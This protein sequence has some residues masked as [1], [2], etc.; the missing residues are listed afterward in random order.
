M[1]A[2]VL[3]VCLTNNIL[4]Y[5][6]FVATA[7][8]STGIGTYIVYDALI[9]IIRPLHSLHNMYAW[10]NCIEGFPTPVAIAIIYFSIIINTYLKFREY[11]TGL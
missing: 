3:N 7:I 1:K 8:G 6:C 9:H 2:I 5:I 11:R 4:L 10:N